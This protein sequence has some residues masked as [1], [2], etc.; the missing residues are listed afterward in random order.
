MAMPASK[1]LSLTRVYAYLRSRGQWSD[2]E[3]RLTFVPRGNTETQVPA[4]RL[5]GSAQ[6]TIG[7][8]T[9]RIE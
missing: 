8:V 6:A 2:K 9:L 7:K 5:G 1:R 3:V 4:Q